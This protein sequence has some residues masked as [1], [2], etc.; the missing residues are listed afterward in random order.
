MHVQSNKAQ[1]RY[2]QGNS[3]SNDRYNVQWQT[4]SKLNLIGKASLNPVLKPNHTYYESK[5][6]QDLQVN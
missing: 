5:L 6:N 4:A 1:A 2:D 3:S